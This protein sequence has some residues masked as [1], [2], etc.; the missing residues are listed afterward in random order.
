MYRL[1]LFDWCT[2]ISL[3]GNFYIIVLF[4]VS[5]NGLDLLFSPIDYNSNYTYCC[6]LWKK[7]DLEKPSTSVP[8]PRPHSEAQTNPSWNFHY[9]RSSGYSSSHPLSDKWTVPSSP[10]RP[11][12]DTSR[13]WPLALSPIT[14]LEDHWDVSDDTRPMVRGPGFPHSMNTVPYIEV[15]CTACFLT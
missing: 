8:L 5:F 15:A 4:K 11:Y 7:R 9:S 1:Y 3:W 13:L 10:P 14:P 6:F 12:P 2:A